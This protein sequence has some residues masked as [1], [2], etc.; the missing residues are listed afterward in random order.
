MTVV[1][2]D[3]DYWQ[4]HCVS[5][6]EELLDKIKELSGHSITVSFWTTAMLPTRPCGARNAFD[7]GTLPEFMCCGQRRGICEAEQPKDLVC[8][9]SKAEITDDSEVQDRKA[10]QDYLDSNQNSFRIRI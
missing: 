7:F 10:A 9:V 8:K 2:Y 3:R 4:R 1:D 5:T 6:T